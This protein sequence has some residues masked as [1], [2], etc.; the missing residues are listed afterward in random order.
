MLNYERIRLNLR[1]MKNISMILT[2][3]PRNNENIKKFPPII[4][5]IPDD[6]E[7]GKFMNINW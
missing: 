7:N 4:M 6:V 3:M 2:E 1:G 5:R